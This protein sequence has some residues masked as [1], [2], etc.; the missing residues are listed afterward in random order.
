MSAALTQI[1]KPSDLRT[2]LRAVAMNL[3]WSWRPIRRRPFEMIDALAWSSMK[4]APLKVLAN[5]SDDRLAI[6]GG[7]DLF[8]E[9]LDAAETDALPALRS[10]PAN[11]RIAYFCSEYAIHESIA[12]YAGG[13]GVLAG[14]HI[15]QAADCGLPLCAI[16]L[17]YGH[18]YYQQEL[19]HAGLTRVNLPRID[20]ETMPITDTGKRIVCPVGDRLVQAR[21]W[22][23][24]VGR[25]PLYLLDA[26]LPENSNEDRDLTLGLYRGEP[27]LRLRQQVLLGVG[28]VIAL[29]AMKETPS[30]F[31]L[32]EGHAAFVAIE[33]LR[34]LRECGMPMSEA[35]AKV[36]ATTVFTTHTPV[37]AGHD[38]YT[39]EDVAAALAQTIRAANISTR[40]LA[41]LG[42]EIPAAVK[43]SF[44]M[45]VLALRTSRFANGVAQLHGEVSREMWKGI[46]WG[47]TEPLTI[48]SITN[49]IHFPTWCDPAVAAFWRDGCRIDVG[50]TTIGKQG[51]E[52]ASAADPAALWRLRSQL[53]ARLVQFVRERCAR[54]SRA[55]GE[56]SRGEL[57]ALSLLRDGALTIGFAR[58]FATYK[59]AILI[60]SDID[61]LARILRNANR[62]VQIVFA[63]KAHPRDAGGQEFAKRVFEMARDARLDGSV[64]MVE[65]YD[66]EV[67]RIL[68]S[69]ADVWLNNPI[70]PY[71]ASGT[72]GM[73]P[74]LAGGL[75]LSILD[76]WWPEGFDG[77]NGW[78]PSLPPK[79]ATAEQIDA[80]DANALY[81]ILEQEVVPTF[82][83]RSAS[84]LPLRWIEMSL[85]SA[86]TIPPM[87]SMVRMLDEYVEKA[88]CPGVRPR[89]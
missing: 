44:C 9:A 73:K 39:H 31:H 8:L 66:M 18:G 62:P 43:E 79:R 46:D 86:Q 13:L 52:R 42:R 57:A 54:Q 15:K 14:D 82:Y 49:G 35:M 27:S 87:F 89:K 64:A 56:G 37:L 81:E 61:R 38:R 71:E 1:P 55:R 28:G 10:Y 88:Y 23:A 74:P 85:R 32:N 30:V 65:D 25:V 59:R 80:H 47:D 11:L 78:A 72:S 50:A 22:L 34:V 2:R 5:A 75:N 20:V 68:T 17:L 63:G 33:R 24:Q 36:R 84:G 19:D 69:G 58:R 67:G 45:T 41:N 29:A 76:G 6:L 60:F 26:D 77:T 40:D 51:W 7:D 53:R 70:H 83:D 12:Q 16:G 21:I 4:G 48:D 3:A